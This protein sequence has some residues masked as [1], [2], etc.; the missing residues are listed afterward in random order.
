L[1]PPA[2][3]FISQ[4]TAVLETPATVAVNCCGWNN[5]IVAVAGEIPMLSV[6]V[7]D[8]LPDLV[9]ST[10]L[11]AAMETAAGLGTVAGAVYSPDV[12][13]VPALLLP[14]ATPFTDQVT[15]WLG[16]FVPWTSALH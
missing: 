6:T 1:F 14:P 8:E 16:L 7:T 9:L 3:P 12:E 15:D 10:V 5:W 13:M 4:S 2:A 11:V